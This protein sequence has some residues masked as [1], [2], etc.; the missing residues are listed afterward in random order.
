MSATTKTVLAAALAMGAGM[1][2]ASVN[3]YDTT[4]FAPAKI[5]GCYLT[6]SNSCLSDF[7]Q[8]GSSTFAQV[9]T[10][11]GTLSDGTQNPS[12]VGLL[13]DFTFYLSAQVSSFR[14]YVFKVYTDPTG[15][16]PSY[17]DPLPPLWTSGLLNTAQATASSSAGQPKNTGPFKSFTITTP[18]LALEAGQQYALM[19]SVEG[20]PAPSGAVNSFVAATTQD[21]YAGG[22]I[23]VG[24]AGSPL[25]NFADPAIGF[26]CSSGCYGNNPG[27]DLVFKATVAIPEPG[28]YALMA[29]GIGA[30][31]F[32]ARRRRPSGA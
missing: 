19:I 1:A 14:A 7:G 3:P 10:Y 24:A 5:S 4:S 32:V 21:A 9:I 16:N 30:I 25:T 11:D 6:T 31:A 26:D 20:I 29:A 8:G 27:S 22:E 13:K 17:T 2:N 15:N 23:L 28:T 12:L 18:S